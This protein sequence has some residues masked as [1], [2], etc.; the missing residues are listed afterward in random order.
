MFS[1]KRF[2]LATVMMAGIAASNSHAASPLYCFEDDTKELSV[3]Y[4]RNDGDG[5]HAKYPVE[6][7]FA[8]SFAEH[9]KSKGVDIVTAEEFMKR[10]NG[11]IWDVFAEGAL[12]A[13]EK[14]GCPAIE[15]EYRSYFRYKEFNALSSNDPV[16][17]HLAVLADA[18]HEAGVCDIPVRKENF[19]SIDVRSKDDLLQ[20]FLCIS[21][22]ESVFG[23][24]N[25]G[26]GGRGPW[27]INPGHT[28]RKG[29]YSY[30]SGSKQ[31]LKKDGICY[32]SKAVARDENGAELKVNS[33]YFDEEV[34]LDNAKCALTL[35][36]VDGSLGGFSSWGKGKSWGSNRHCSKTTRDRLKFTKFLGTKACCSSA[37]KDAVTGKKTL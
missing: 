20:H 8:V 30:I 14:M 23:Q 9:L 17:K 12:A 3:F 7:I 4:C 25:I 5:T 29:T 37:C 31:K 26:M 6:P 34:I 13:A 19:N 11:N 36:K 2:L 27:G 21:N 22:S 1:L 35:Y 33:L 32:P 15:E 28:Q 10:S 24:S 18:L 16:I